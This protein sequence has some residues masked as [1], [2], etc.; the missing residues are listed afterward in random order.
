MQGFLVSGR[1]TLSF[2]ARYR[3]GLD[4]NRRTVEKQVRNPAK[5]TECFGTEITQTVLQN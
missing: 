1:N 4:R 3:E 2:T 5:P